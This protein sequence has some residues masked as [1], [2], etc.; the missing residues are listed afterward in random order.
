MIW[1]KSWLLRVPITF[2]VGTPLLV[3]FIFLT[4][5]YGPYFNHQ[6]SERDS[7]TVSA[8]T[9][10]ATDPGSNPGEGKTNWW[11]DLVFHCVFGATD[12]Q[13]EK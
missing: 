10:H 9:R 8:F 1:L 3:E 6:L 2:L 11:L 4:T 5:F 12:L 7:L 13:D